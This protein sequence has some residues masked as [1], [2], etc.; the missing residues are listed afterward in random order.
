MHSVEDISRL[1][2]TVFIV[3]QSAEDEANYAPV[4][5]ASNGGF[6]SLIVP[7][8]LHGEANDKFDLLVPL[9]IQYDPL[10]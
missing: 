7:L 2:K 1:T 10:I 9:V 4:G 5:F 8:L 3:F 6:V